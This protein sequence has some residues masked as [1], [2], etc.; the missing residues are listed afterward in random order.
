MTQNYLNN[1]LAGDKQISLFLNENMLKMS[2][3]FHIHH[4]DNTKMV[5]EEFV[6]MIKTRTTASLE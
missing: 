6:S 1:W 4:N 2:L 3:I 5:T